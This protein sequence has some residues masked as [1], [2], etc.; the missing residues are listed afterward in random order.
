MPKDNEN[1]RLPFMEEVVPSEPQ[2]FT[3]DQMI[4]CDECLRANPPTRI[5][6]LYCSAVLPLNEASLKLRKP[7]LRPPEK[8]ELGYNIIIAPNQSVL[9]STSVGDAAVLLKLSPENLHRNLSAAAPLPLARTASPEEAQ[10]VLDRLSDLGLI[11]HILSDQ[12]LGLMPEQVTRVRSMNLDDNGAALKPSATTE[13][14]YFPWSN[15]VLIV[16]GRLVVRRVEVKERKMRKDE[17]EIL[18]TSEFFQDQ[19]VIDLYFDRHSETWRIPT[20]GFDFSCLG[21]RK[22]LVANENILKLLQTITARSTN[23]VVHDGYSLARKLLDPVWSL[24]QETQS[25]GW[26]RESPGK[27]SLGAATTETNESQFTRYS[28]LQFYLLTH[29]LNDKN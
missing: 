26:R 5:A 29:P 10:L 11:A 4:R 27:Y 17:N 13:P 6:C 25:S 24:E 19:A 7:T 23:A 9:P 12:D 3:H 8:H 2:G 21:A 28:R 18:S 16:T 1:V 15:V 22:S 20:N 14:T